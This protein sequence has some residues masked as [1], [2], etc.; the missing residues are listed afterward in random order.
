MIG[1]VALGARGPAA[2]VFSS[3]IVLGPPSV[4]HPVRVPNATFRDVGL[5]AARRVGRDQQRARDGRPS[6]RRLPGEDRRDAG[7]RDRFAHRRRRA[8][9]QSGDACPTS[10]ARRSIARPSPAKRDSS[11]SA[12]GRSASSRTTSAAI[13]IRISR[14]CCLRARPRRATSCRTSRSSPR[15]DTT[16]TSARGSDSRTSRARSRTSTTPTTTSSRRRS[17]PDRIGIEPRLDL[18][19][20]QPREGPHPGRRARGQR[21]VRRRRAERAAVRQRRRTPTARCSKAR[22]RSPVSS[23]ADKPQDNITP[24]KLNGGLR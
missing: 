2:T 16:W 3:P 23:L 12:A 15:T 14:N 10:T 7:L 5:F 24:W 8:A 4:D 18:A 19:S 22:A 21:T 6:P 11:C 13:V 9:D 20:H 17:W 1:R